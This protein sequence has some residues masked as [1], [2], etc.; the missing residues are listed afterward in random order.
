M[1]IPSIIF[2]PTS[3]LLPALYLGIWQQCP[4]CHPPAPQRSFLL[5]LIPISPLP[6]LPLKQLRESPN[7]HVHAVIP[8]LY[9]HSKDGTT[10]LKPPIQVC[11]S[12]HTLND[13]HDFLLFAENKL[14]RRLLSS[15]ESGL[16]QSHLITHL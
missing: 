12:I 7:F 1:G 5:H 8:C 2:P 9:Y 14:A 13:F 16:Y 4:C 11:S 6:L 3:L 15:A 10:N